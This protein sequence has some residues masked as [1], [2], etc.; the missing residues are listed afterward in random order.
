MPLTPDQAINRVHKLYDRLAGRRAEID[1]L[2]Q[3]FRGDQKLAYASDEWSKQH[4]KRYRDFADNW[5]V[6]VGS[7][8][9]ER[10]EVKGFRLGDGTGRLSDDEQWLRRTWEVNELP[11]QS[12][13]GFL[14]ST[15]SKRSAVL[16]WAD[17]DG[18]PEVTW[19]H[20][21]QV[22][23]DYD[24]TSTRRRRAAL[25]AW[26]DGKTEYAT[27][28]MPDEIWKFERAH[29]VQ[30]NT[31]RT[32][33]GLYLTS[34]SNNRSGH[35]LE[36]EDTGDAEWPLTNPLGVVPIVEFRNRP[37][38]DGEPLSDIAGTMA[39][40]DAI[41]MLWAYLFVAADYASMPARVVTGQEPP[42][43]PILD[44]LGNKVG[45]KPVDIAELTKGRMLW[46]TGQTTK[47]DQW[48]AAKLDVFTDVIN[49]SVRHVAAQTRTPIY[50]IHGEL[51]NVNGET[52]TGLDAPLV[53]KVRESHTFYTSPVREVH[54]LMA[55]VRGDD[56]L[57]DACR[58]GIVQWANPETRSD[59]Q[60]SDAALKDSQIGWPF[61]AILERRYDLGQTEI[62]RVLEQQQ[63]ERSDPTLEAVARSLT[64]PVASTGGP[65]DP[66]LN[67]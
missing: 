35:W 47:V 39:M 10:T 62:D 58:S 16:V 31:G 22:I 9:G 41:N 23:V 57:A 36:R 1:K 59:A 45:D 44:S 25:K 7:A 6:V 15:V 53:S 18:E 11:A 64:G 26:V 56:R 27:L 37:M 3:Y 34:V 13:Q 30:Q 51:G 54:R 42:K 49:V 29:E 38:L 52:L 65:N 28:Y 20:P 43:V 5:C 33:S 50:L 2:E 19:E 61:A 40:Q 63:A 66:A 55:M 32:E 46:L 21:S 14:T 24:P 48:D 4:S 67:G 8:P 12:S 60:V 17:E